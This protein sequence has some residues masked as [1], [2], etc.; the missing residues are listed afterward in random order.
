MKGTIMQVF[1]CGQAV[2]A[3]RIVSIHGGEYFQFTPA[4]GRERIIEASNP[5]LSMGKA[6]RPMMP[7]S[8]SME[9]MHAH[10]EQGRRA[11]GRIA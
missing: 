9:A 10:R 2:E 3:S 1:F 4:D 6:D 5:C 7:E 11:F 8:I